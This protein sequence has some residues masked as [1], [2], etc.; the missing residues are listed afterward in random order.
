[1]AIFGAVYTYTGSDFSGTYSLYPIWDSPDRHYQ[2]ENG[3]FAAS[4]TFNY[5]GIALIIISVLSMGAFRSR[6]SG[7]GHTKS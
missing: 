5:L 2:L 1:M 3:T 7:E 6:D 4:F